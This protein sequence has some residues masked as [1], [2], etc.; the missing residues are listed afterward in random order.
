MLSFVRLFSLFQSQIVTQN[1]YKKI[2]PILSS[3]VKFWNFWRDCGIATKNPT[4]QF[5][6]VVHEVWSIFMLTSIN[7]HA[8]RILSKAKLRNKR[9]RISHIETIKLRIVCQSQTNYSLSITDQL[10]SIAL[11]SELGL[12]LVNAERSSILTL[13]FMLSS[14]YLCASEN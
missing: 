5:V 3:K 13:L 14:T 2:W 9:N 1:S 7:R 8:A 12:A 10:Q 4:T 6:I 11:P